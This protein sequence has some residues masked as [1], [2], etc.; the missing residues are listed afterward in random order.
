MK[1]T[2]QAKETPPQEQQNQVWHDCKLKV[3][4]LP[5]HLK[6]RCHV[7]VSSTFQEQFFLGETVF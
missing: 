3:D 5:A 6:S 7:D 4:A 1:E 2:M